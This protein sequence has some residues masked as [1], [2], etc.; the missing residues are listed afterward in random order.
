MAFVYDIKLSKLD[1]EPKVSDVTPFQS[2]LVLAELLLARPES[3]DKAKEELLALEQQNP[4]SVELQEAM[5]FSSES[6]R[7]RECRAR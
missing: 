3:A 1:L 6:R 4:N 7:S 2:K 5:G